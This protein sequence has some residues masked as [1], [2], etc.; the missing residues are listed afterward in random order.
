MTVLYG[1]VLVEKDHP[2][3]LFRGKIESLQ[4]Q[5]ILVQVVI[6]ERGG[7]QKLLDDLN[8]ILTILR[9]ILRSHV[10]NQPLVVT[11]IIGLTPA[12]VHEREQNPTQFYPVMEKVGTPEYT[13]GL[14]YAQLN[15]LYTQMR[16]VETVA[17]T[18]LREGNRYIRNDILE[19]LNSLSSTL[20]VMMFMHLAGEYK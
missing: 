2:Q 6:A 5:I 19:V 17:I 14:E 20:R 10:L 1:D 3:I 11:N 8:N 7:S 9:N 18:A 16:E 12:E 4:S 13:R 15:Q